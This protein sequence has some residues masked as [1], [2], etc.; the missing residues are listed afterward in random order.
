MDPKLD[1][2]GRSD[3]DIATGARFT[4]TCYGISNPAFH[5]SG[6]YWGYPRGYLCEPSQSLLDVAPHRR[7]ELC[8]DHPS[9]EA[10]LAFTDPFRG[11]LVYTLGR[12]VLL[13]NLVKS[14][15]GGWLGYSS[16]DFHAPKL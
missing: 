10:V 15:K 16:L 13:D 9:R 6:G 14:H 3:S 2:K 7:G 5:G 11:T 8:L 1:L 4:C 12:Q